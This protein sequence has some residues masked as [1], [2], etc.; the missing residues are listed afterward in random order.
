MT[1]AARPSTPTPVRRGTL[2]WLAIILFAFLA[3]LGVLGAAAAV[4]VY[5]SMSSGLPP[6]ADL[7]KYQ[8]P[9]ETVIYDRTGTI[10]L[11]RF[12]EFQRDVVTFDEIPPVLLDATT[13]IEDK[14]FWQN[15]GFDPIGIVAAGLDAVRGDAR[16]ASTITQQ[17]V[18]ARLLPENL[19][20]DPHRTIERKLKEIIQSIRLTQSFSGETGKQDI[21]TAYL[22]QNYYGNQAYGVKAAAR[23]YFGKALM[24]ITPAEAAILAALPKSPSNYDL[25]RNANER[26]TVTVADGEDCPAGKSELV[27]EPDSKIVQRRN[28]VLDLLAGGDR[29]PMSGSQYSSQVFEAA[30]DDEVILASQATPRWIAPHFVWAVRDELATKLCGEGVGSCDALDNGGLRVTTTL[31]VGLQKIAEK[32]VYAAAV[33]PHRKDPKAAAKSIGFDSL[34][35]WIKKLEDKDV[36][37]GALVAIDYQ[38]GEVISY[39]GSGNYYSTSTKPEFQPQYDVAGSG[40]RQPGSAFKPFNY[41]TGINDETFTAGSML[42]DVGT[43]FGG[44]YAPNDADRLER[45]P[46]RVRK[47]LQFSLN[48]PSVKAMALNEPDHVFATAKEFGMTFQSDT[49]N[50][51]L[52]LALG[53]AETRPVDLTTAYGTLANGGGRIDHTTILAVDGPPGQ[54]GR[55]SVRAAGAGPGRQPPVGLHRDRHPEREHHQGGQPVLG[56]VRDRGREGPSSPGDAQDRHEQRREGPQRLRLHRATDASRSRRRAVR[57]RRRRLERQ[58]RQHP[59]L[60]RGPPGRLARRPDLRLAGLHDGGHRQVADHQVRAT[61]RPGRRRHR[62][63]DRRQGHGLVARRSPRSSSR[64]RS[65]SRSRPTPA[66]SSSCATRRSASRP[67]ARA[68][69]PPT[70]TG[71]PAPNAVLASG[72]DRT[73]RRRA[74]STTSSSSRTAPRGA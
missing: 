37:N 47:A 53:V 69:W 45:G 24:D 44:G 48:I 19:V 29:T 58:L 35:A 39:V 25:V 8:L 22:N 49:T 34:P 71:W 32:W 18:R 27:V 66:A 56:R 52:A 73:G 43:D 72:A 5:A 51:G 9:E 65:P 14:T 42:M 2:G 74:T 7:T 64:G 41:V 63:V 70:W 36:H 61:G 68:G 11:A 30:K 15:A 40:Y 21:I 62:P 55:R 59:G 3:T 50:A 33:V 60:D 46:V 26:C 31:D 6:V 12:G 28:Q 57:A 10:E 17:L 4:T 38:T 16:G 20:Q 13:A 67:T 23:I 54:A 1:A